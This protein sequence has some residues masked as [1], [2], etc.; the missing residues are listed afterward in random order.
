MLLCSAPGR[1]PAAFIIW[2]GEALLQQS[3]WQ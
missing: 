3:L 2:G 1:G